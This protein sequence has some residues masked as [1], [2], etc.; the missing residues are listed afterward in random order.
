MGDDRREEPAPLRKLA[1]GFASRTFATAKLGLKVG[2]KYAARTVAGAASSKD[3][4]AEAKRVADAVKS[5][6]DLVKQLGALKG[7]AMKGGQMIS[8]LHGAMPPEAQKV[9]ARLQAESTPM[10]FD[11]VEQV[12]REEL[13]G[14]ADE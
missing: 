14:G 2:A 3:P 1:S 13:G 12:L 8:Y 11:V 6:E 10:A 5:A 9:L 4:A 7:L